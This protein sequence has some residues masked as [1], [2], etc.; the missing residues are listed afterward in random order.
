MIAGQQNSTINGDGQAAVPAL[1]H[2]GAQDQLAQDAPAAAE[3][4]GDV[5]QTDA[6]ADAAVGGDDLEDNVED[7]V[8]DR[9]TVEGARLAD[10]DEEYGEDDP[11]EIVR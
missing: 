4:V 7:A 8:V 1:Q 11:P 5:R 3:G 9:V 10:G 2:D 6:D